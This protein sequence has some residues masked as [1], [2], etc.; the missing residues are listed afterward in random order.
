MDLY[1]VRLSLAEIKFELLFIGYQMTVNGCKEAEYEGNQILAV[2]K[3]LN[4]L[5]DVL[6]RENKQ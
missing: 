1:F 6:E 2:I 3:K 5:E 4:E